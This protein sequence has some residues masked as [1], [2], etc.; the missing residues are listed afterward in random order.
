MT[1][2]DQ[3]CRSELT[4]LSFLSASGPAVAVGS[5]VDVSAV[6]HLRGI[7]P[8]LFRMVLMTFM[9]VE[10]GRKVLFLGLFPLLLPPLLFCSLER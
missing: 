10:L 8:T 5:S 7:F 6:I 2:S 1:F 3:G 9:E 4:F